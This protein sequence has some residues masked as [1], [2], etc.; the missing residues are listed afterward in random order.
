MKKFLNFNEYLQDF[1]IKDPFERFNESLIHTYPLNFFER[2]LQKFLLDTGY[3]HRFLDDIILNTLELIM[4]SEDFKD[5]LLKII[6]NEANF[7]G[8]KIA[9]IVLVNPDKKTTVIKNVDVNTSNIIKDAEK[10][11]VHIL[12]ESNFDKEF[13]DVPKILYH[14]TLTKNVSKIMSDGLIP[15]S[16]K[17]LSSHSDR[18]YFA[19]SEDFT[20]HL[21]TMMSKIDDFPESDYSI[22][23]IDTSTLKV[24]FMQDPN[25]IR[26]TGQILGIYT[27][28]NIPPNTISL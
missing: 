24:K 6:I 26:T 7:C 27:H 8:Y 9:Q 22:L 3:D 14:V 5:S 28:E 23:K 2:R 16:K 21:L 15:K 18:V 20:K 17:K 13:M 10:S 12:F 11:F 25:S 19:L 1:P 4:D